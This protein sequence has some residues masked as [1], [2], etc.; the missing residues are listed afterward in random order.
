MKYKQALLEKNLEANMLSKGLQ[1]KISILEKKVLEAEETDDEDEKDELLSS[2]EKEDLFLAGK[3]MKFDFDKYRNKV[4]VLQKNSAAKENKS[5]SKAIV[6]VNADNGYKLKIEGDAK[7][8]PEE[9]NE[10]EEFKENSE[11]FQPYTKSKM[12]K[13][14][15]AKIFIGV[16]LAILTVGVIDLL[17]EE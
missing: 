1:Q 3:I 13:K 15:R 10:V 8:V 16:A 17:R 12:T 9:N 5:P 4:S 7:P 6:P 14:N 11:T 2:I